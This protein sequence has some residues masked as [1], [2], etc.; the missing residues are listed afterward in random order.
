MKNKDN[1]LYSERQKPLKIAILGPAYPYRGG[2]AQGNHRL[3]QELIKQGHTVNIYTFTLQY[4]AFLFPGKTQ[5]SPDSAPVDIPIKR[6]I[7]SINPISWI[8]TVLV[9]RRQKPQILLIRYWHPFMAPCFTAICLLLKLYNLRQLR[10]I[11]LTDNLLSHEQYFGET[12]LTRIFLKIPHAF[13]V[14]SQKILQDLHKFNYKGELA[15]NPHPLFDHFGA[16]IPRHEALAKLKLNSNKRYLLFFGLIRQYKGL[17]LLLE[18]M[19]DKRIAK[20]DLEL[21]V[22]G[23]FYTNSQIYYEQLAKLNI[24]QKVHFFNYFIPDNEVGNYFGAA[25]LLVQ[26]YK[27]ATQS[28]ISQIAYHFDKPMIL[29]KVGGLSETIKHGLNG[30]SVEANPYAIAT[31][32]ADFYQ[33]NKMQAMTAQM[34][35][36]KERYSWGNMVQTLI[37]TYNKLI[38]P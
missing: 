38:K 12:I 29:T 9:L 1:S 17:D 6:I 30:Y 34:H 21:I 2:I 22:A 24:Q 13:I 11:I 27:N 23:E 15:Y 8:K 19:S 18:A 20:L 10:I 4:P 37:Q 33:Y 28:G 7:S 36:N 35:I 25:D 5:F 3:A 31:A 14:M 16:I 32:I 26:P